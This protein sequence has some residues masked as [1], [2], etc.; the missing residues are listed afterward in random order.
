MS[1]QIAILHYASPPTVGGVEATIAHHAR[2]LTKLGYHVRVISGDGAVFDNR[3]ESKIYPSFA[4]RH[5]DVL[6]VKKELDKGIVSEAFHELV[7][8]QAAYLQ[9]A[10]QDCELC[11]V[12]N[13]HSLNKNLSLTAALAS[14][15]Q[16]PLIAWVHD[17]A[18]TN[19]Q[20]QDELHDGYPWNLL[21][22]KWENSRY[23]T[24]SEARQVE[25]AQLMGIQEEEIA[26]VTAGVDIAAFM[27]WTESMQMIDEKLQ[28]L[29]ADLLLLLP[30]RLTRRKN[31]EFALCVLD[32]L[33]KQTSNDCRLIVSGPP[34]PHNPTNKD[35]LGELLALRQSLDLQNAAH[36][37]YELEEPTFIPDDTTMANLYQTADALFFPSLDEGLGIPILEAGLVGLPIFCSDL[38]PFRQTGQDNLNFFDPRHDSPAELARMIGTYFSDNPREV[39]KR[40]VRHNYRWELI[41]RNQIIPLVEAL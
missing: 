23:V 32:E 38:P 27:Q 14:L 35:Y 22:Q 36:F 10:L 41:V 13:I 21:R 34:G 1:K 17:M 11:I 40:R 25:F 29:S 37:L 20:Y 30:A 26:V 6:T 8:K 16:I 12:H 2:G 33:R 31:I 15:E 24:V 3:I 18:W 28:L 7:A 9:E 4:S 5:E 39:L 19:P